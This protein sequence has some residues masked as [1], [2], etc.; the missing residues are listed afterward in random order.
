[1]TGQIP[2]TFIYRGERYDM[3]GVRGGEL[4]APEQFG[5]TPVSMSSACWRGFYVTYELAS[6]GLFLREL[7]LREEDDEYKPI[8]GV[9]P[10]GEQ[11]EKAYSN[12][13]VRVPFTGK[14]RVARDFIRGR[15]VHMGF[16]SPTAYKTVHDVTLEDG[17]V[18][19]II[20]R[21]NEVEKLREE[22]DKRPSVDDLPG[23]AGW[24]DKR[25]SLDMDLE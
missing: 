19:D 5:M 24:I 6:E 23:L 12:L 13:N 21:S 9:M 17:M 7:V 15:Y 11:G 2:D 14:I 3:I 20:D 1:M 4:V 22:I 10:V 16:Q 8:D 25:F 18:K